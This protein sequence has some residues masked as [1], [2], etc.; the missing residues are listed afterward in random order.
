[1]ETNTSFRS[2]QTS[3]PVSVWNILGVSV[4]QLITS[5]IKK[6]MGVTQA[7]TKKVGGVDIGS[8]KKF[9]GVSNV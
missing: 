9:M 4:N 5:Q 3:T 8:T 1:M 7:T 6:V 2:A